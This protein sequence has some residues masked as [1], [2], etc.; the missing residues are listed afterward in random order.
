M[1]TLTRSQDRALHEIVAEASPN[2]IM[3]CDEAGTILFANH[4]VQTIFGYAPAE[5]MGLSVDR[6]LPVGTRGAHG[7]EGQLLRAEPET[8]RM[9]AGR[10]LSGRR[11]DG[12][13]V[14][15]EVALTVA[16]GGGRRLVV[17]TVV[18]ITDRH[19]LR[20]TVHEQAGH[21]VQF[22]QLVANL[23]VRFVSLAPAD[24]DEVVVDSQRQI[25]QTLDI[26]RCVL[27]QFTEDRQDLV[28]T[29]TW[30]RPEFRPAPA[31]VSARDLFPWFFEKIKAGES[32]WFETLDQVP[33]VLDR[34]NLRRFET[35]S[36]AIV[37]M[38]V[39]G[40]V[41]GALSFASMREERAWT[42]QIM[43]RL[44]LIAAVFAQVLAR[45]ESQ[46]QLERAL[47]EVERLRDQL[48]SENVQLR[49][50]VTSLKA[51]KSIAAESEAVRKAL[52][53]VELVAPTDSTVLLLG[54]TGCG[55]EVFAQAIH[56][57]SPRRDRPMVRVNCAAIPTALLE[58]ELFGRERG[59][60]TG[61]LSRQ[62]GR[63]E[64][65]SGT[66]IFL[67]EV[68]DLP[69]EAQVKLLRI[70]QDR[71]LERL[72]SIRPIK[73][74]VRVIAATNRDL[75]KAVSERAFREDLFY[76]LNVFPIQVPPLRERPDDIPV[77]IWAFIDEFSK[78]F[79]KSIESI[80]KTSLTALRRHPWPG[81]VRE[82]RNVIER[83]VIVAKGPVLVVE[84]FHSEPG[85]NSGS[86]N[87]SDVEREHIRE[88]LDKVQWRVRGEGGAADLLGIKPTTLESRMAKLGIQRP[89]R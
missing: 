10:E 24:V 31:A 53:Q 13:E 45:K 17:A 86:L 14:P 34:E 41:L 1:T 23:A 87:L 38:E 36:N 80:A 88:V 19:G 18:D 60:Y 67:D 11:K 51:P 26:D 89:R 77:L 2:G 44:R 32:V 74:D 12:S 64:L 81:N 68:G 43:D 66:T 79:N 83:A 27:W 49:H 3:V 47:A 85:A 35:K 73:V 78:A 22:E 52:A 4:Q 42:H 84:P 63:F 71:T 29:H 15:V 75:R 33:A 20:R 82:L 62:I 54:E 56:D 55:K 6:L 37:P 30:S 61:A 65:A 16:S 76:R 69:L 21:L 40:R 39:N 25:V 46:L 28:Y 50:E 5:L 9:E 70:L 59:A 57:Q 58:S 8:K 48:A 7:G 72:G